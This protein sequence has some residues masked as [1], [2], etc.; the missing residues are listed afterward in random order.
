MFILK[1]LSKLLFGIIAIFVPEDLRPKGYVPVTP[2]TGGGE[3]R[4]LSEDQICKL[5]NES[6]LPR[7]PVEIKADTKKIFQTHI[8]QMNLKRLPDGREELADPSAAML[9]VMQGD[10][11]L[12][13]KTAYNE[14][15]KE[16]YVGFL[17]LT[18]RR[19]QF[20]MGEEARE[21]HA[22]DTNRILPFFLDTTKLKSADEST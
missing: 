19:M 5:R 10:W 12:P 1:F 15:P 7:G 8:T 2:I 17:V 9:F 6:P 11:V 22:V 3:L 21:R 14:A 4:A 18:D 13:V 16:S 20:Q